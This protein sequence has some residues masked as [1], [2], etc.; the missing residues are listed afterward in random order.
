MRSCDICPQPATTIR[1]ATRGRRGSKPTSGFEQAVY[2]DYDASRYLGWPDKY[3]PLTEAEKD[4]KA[5]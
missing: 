2:C 5:E 1:P 3:R 4:E